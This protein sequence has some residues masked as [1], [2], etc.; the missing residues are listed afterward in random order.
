MILNPF[1]DSNFI[2][3][4]RYQRNDFDYE[5]KA[6]IININSKLC[7][8]ALSISGQYG[9]IN[10]HID[11]ILL[12]DKL[13]E[14]G[15]SVKK[16]G[17]DT[18]DISFAQSAT[19]RFDCKPTNATDVYIKLVSKTVNNIINDL[20]KSDKIYIEVELDYNQLQN[21]V[22]KVLKE[23]GYYIKKYSNVNYFDVSLLPISEDK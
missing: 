15:Y 2:E 23:S 11:S 1:I 8:N 6:D 16:T 10:A 20:R 12:I 22:I 3:N 18:Y 5:L 17:D 7:E 4:L 19:E 21:D 9:K 14:L 13:E